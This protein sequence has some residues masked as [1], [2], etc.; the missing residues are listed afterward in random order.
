MKRLFL[1][2]VLVACAH[3][4]KVAQDPYLWLEEIEGVEPLKWV[5]TQN[6]KSLDSLGSAARY[7]KAE[8]EVLAIL[9]A[10]DKIP[11]GFFQGS[12]IINFW[13]DDIHVRGLLRKTSYSEYKKKNPRW[14]TILDIDLLAKKEN[15][16]WV[17]KGMD[18]LEP[19]Y[20]ICMVSLSRGGKDATVERE[21]NLKTKKFVSS[22][23]T[24]PEA[25]SVL[26]WADKDHLLV[27]TDFGAGSLT[28][29]GYP[30]Q[31]R[32]WKRGTPL[33]KA[34]TLMN[35]E[36]KDV[37][38]APQRL[39]HKN[40]NQ[41]VLVRAIDFFNTE[42]SVVDLK[43]AAVKIVPKPPAAQLSGYFQ[44]QF[45]YKLR[46]PWSFN[47]AQFGAGA[48]ISIAEHAFGRN[49]T[50]QDVQ[51][52][53][54]PKE[55]QAVQSVT[56]LK[57]KVIIAVLEDVKSKTYSTQLV[58]GK[59]QEPVVL[60]LGDGGQISVVTSSDQ[61]DLFLYLYEN[62][63]QPS[64]LYAFEFGR[65]VEKLKSSPDR[66]DANNL[67]VEQ[68]FATS[69]DGIKVPYFIV[70][71]KGLI[72][73]GT[74][75][76]LQYGYGGFTVSQ[77][78]QY[79]AI[80]GK[81]WLEKGGVYVVANIRGGGEYGPRW[82][83]AALKENRQ[84]AYDDFIAVSE[85]LIANKV[86]SPSRLAIRGGSNGGLL[87]GAVMAQRPDLYGAVLCWVPLL[88][89]IRY[90]QLLAGASW[91]GEYGDPQD[92]KYREVILKYSP[93][94]NVSADKKY[95]PVLFVTSTKDDRVH[96]GHARKMAAKMIDQ[97]H[98]VMYYEN[99]E[100]GHGA[101]ANLKQLA[102]LNALQYE[103]LLQ[104]IGTSL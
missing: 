51:L 100:G 25:K 57:S 90:S 9:E 40:K 72:F 49:L 87:V 56:E 101:G 23:F 74:A 2:T 10:K 58:D 34:K 102:K 54:E 19:D 89:M 53:F 86:T 30:R 88:D 26:T 38:A 104:T 52:I 82:H 42:E 77:T 103:F 33:E 13:R 75:P 24:L 31:I 14:Q 41:L 35:I 37:R 59:W 60:K 99:T 20:Q 21:F 94:Q 17:F 15:E 76:T 81:L 64:T 78:A 91:M 36:A 66:F 80:V 73:N 95:P 84:K 11:T 47:G 7:Q 44:G 55:N 46:N 18:C 8:K 50:S 79:N 70:S 71:K 28:D 6:Q 63:N 65:A 97:K 32:L 69:K 16:N 3:Q 68:K 4:P 62:F 45:I 67:Q 43:T 39:V 27:A 92:S 83:Q 61:K 5:E 85:D 93:Y 48:I 1:L 98:F 29:S 22:G 12:D 96:P